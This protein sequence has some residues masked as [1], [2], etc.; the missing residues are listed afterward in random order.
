MKRRGGWRAATAAISGAACL[1]GCSPQGEA[2]SVAEDSAPT[3]GGWLQPPR[4]GGVSVAGADLVIRGLAAPG[5]RVALRSPVGEAFAATA[6]GEG[7][8]E[9][10]MPRPVG[11]RLLSPE[12]QNGEDAASAPDRLLVLSGGPIA[13]VRPGGASLRLD[14]SA[15]LASVDSDG[16][17]LLA[18]GH[19]APGA[20]VTVDLGRGPRTVTADSTGRWVSR[21]VEGVGP[22]L[23]TIN[24]TAFAYPGGAVAQGEGLVVSRAGSG[25]MVSWSLPPGARQSSWFPQSGGDDGLFSSR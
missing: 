20:Q 3:K 8:F 22:T 9:L 10:R 11:D 5:G 2:P 12:I 19:A 21:A 13:L 14:R 25:W 16:G 24:G 15:A 18:A 17:N 7:R 6:D 4:I 1:A 23:I